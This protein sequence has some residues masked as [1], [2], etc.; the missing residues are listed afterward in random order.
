MMAAIVYSS[1]AENIRATIA[2]GNAVCRMGIF[3][4][5]TEEAQLAE[6]VKI[7]FPE[8]CDD[9]YRKIQTNEQETRAYP[10]S[11]MKQEWG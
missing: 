1:S 2:N 4:C 9:L 10:D 6:M 3:A 5:G 11:H 7:V 8:R